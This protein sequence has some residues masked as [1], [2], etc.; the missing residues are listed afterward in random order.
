MNEAPEKEGEN[1]KIQKIT[2]CGINL[3]PIMLTLAL[4]FHAF[5][6]GIAVG[7]ISK[8]SNLVNLIIGILIHK[9]IGSISLGITFAEDE[10]VTIKK[11]ILPF[12][13]FGIT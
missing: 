4:G 7:L 9:S 1:N 8:L 13:G 11:A 12:I 6:E 10:E 5:F 3:T 2:V